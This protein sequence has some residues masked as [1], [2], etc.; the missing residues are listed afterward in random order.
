MVQAEGKTFLGRRRILR[1]VEGDVERSAEA[2]RHSKSS[3]PQISPGFL[4][5]ARTA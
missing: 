1:K 5:Y 2:L 4:L 3:P